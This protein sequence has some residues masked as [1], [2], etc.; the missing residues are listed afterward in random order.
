MTIRITWMSPTSGPKGRAKPYQ[1]MALIA[2]RI[3]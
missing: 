3:S 1:K 2:S